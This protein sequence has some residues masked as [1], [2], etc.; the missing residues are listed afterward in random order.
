MKK[1]YLFYVEYNGNFVANYKSVK[2]CLN[3]I[4]RKKLQDDFDNTLRIVDN[5]G[6]MYNT[7]NGNKIMG[8]TKD[9]DIIYDLCDG[10]DVSECE[11]V[12]KKHFN[13]V[14]FCDEKIDDGLDDGVYLMMRSYDVDDA[15]VR[16]YYG[17]DD[18]IVTS[19]DVSS[20]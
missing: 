14:H 2:A 17:N 15:H 12:L 18:Y 16:L 8:R 20:N 19:I 6:N 7:I 9:Y 1:T 5:N 10:L 11:D 13:E 3:F 4:E